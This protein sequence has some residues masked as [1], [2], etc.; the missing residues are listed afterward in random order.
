EY[1][2]E[3]E[4]KD[5]IEVGR[6][7]IFQATHRDAYSGGQV[8][9]YHVKEE[10]WERVGGYNVLDLYYEYEDLRARK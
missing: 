8:N 10:G 4:T 5:A 7:A 3:M 2:F 6:R 9:V 1:D